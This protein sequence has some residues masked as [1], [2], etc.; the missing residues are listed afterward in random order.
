MRADIPCLLRF[1]R[2][3]NHTV[4]TPAPRRTV[5]SEVELEFDVLAENYWRVH[6][7]PEGT[8]V[9]VGL[10]LI[11]GSKWMDRQGRSGPLLGTLHTYIIMYQS[12]ESG[13]FFLRLD[14]DKSPN[15]FRAYGFTGV[16]AIIH[17]RSIRAAS[18]AVHLRNNSICRV[19]WPHGTLL[20]I[21]PYTHNPTDP[22]RRR[23]GGRGG[24]GGRGQERDGGV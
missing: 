16:P 6:K 10:I 4:H 18:P 15:T 19:D 3:S 23:G 17:V 20:Q 11:G 1:N 7:K 14:Y 13:L 22:A 5:P 8:F 2:R 24:R 21:P 12:K 9:H